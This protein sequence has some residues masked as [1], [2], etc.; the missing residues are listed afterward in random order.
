MDFLPRAEFGLI[1]RGS[2]GIDAGRK[3]LLL[4]CDRFLSKYWGYILETF[5]VVNKF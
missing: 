3:D 1:L 5:F 2:I 4:S